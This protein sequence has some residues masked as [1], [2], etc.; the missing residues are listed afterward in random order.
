MLGFNAD[1]VYGTLS[2]SSTA[3]SYVG[4]SIIGPEALSEGR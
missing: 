2:I 4:G 1:C 3:S